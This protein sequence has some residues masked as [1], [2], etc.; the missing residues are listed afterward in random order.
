MRLNTPT[1]YTRRHTDERWH[2]ETRAEL[3][4]ASIAFLVA[5]YL[6]LFAAPAVF[7]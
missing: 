2:P 3:I 1:A 4:G 5:M 7:R 6:L